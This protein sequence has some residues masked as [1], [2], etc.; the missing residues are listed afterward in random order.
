VRD[1]DEDEDTA[2]PQTRTKHQQIVWDGDEDEEYH[3]LEQTGKGIKTDGCM[4]CEKGRNSV[5]INGTH[6]GYCDEGC[7]EPRRLGEGMERVDGRVF[8]VRMWRGSDRCFRDERMGEGVISN[9]LRFGWLYISDWL[10]WEVFILLVSMLF[11]EGRA[12]QR[13]CR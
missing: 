13:S 7:V 2:R 9:E 10:S 1:E 4:T 12:P 8:G 6:F 3:C 5:S 11:A